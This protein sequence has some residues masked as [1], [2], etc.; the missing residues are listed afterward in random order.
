MFKWIAGVISTISLDYLRPIM[1]HIMGPLVR[2][3]SSG[4]NGNA[5][6]KQLSK[7]VTGLV[8]KKMDANEYQELLRKVEMRLNIRRAE[9]KKVRSQQ[10]ISLNKKMISHLFCFSILIAIF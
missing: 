6:L 8:K 4:E 5:Q 1:F 3:L 2:E 9:R 7:E 10:V